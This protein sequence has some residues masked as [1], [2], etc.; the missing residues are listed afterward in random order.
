MTEKEITSVYKDAI[1]PVH[2]NVGSLNWVFI[3]NDKTIKICLWCMAEK[4]IEL[5]VREVE[6]ED[7]KDEAHN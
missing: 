3:N 2:G 1:C 6:F 5:G 7:R 4:L